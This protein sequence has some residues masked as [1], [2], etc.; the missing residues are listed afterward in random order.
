[1]NEEIWRAIVACDSSFDGRVYYGLKTTGIYC[2]PS[3]KSRTPKQENVRIYHSIAEAHKA[4]LRP[5]KRCRPDEHSNATH[6]EKLAH[7]LANLIDEHYQEPLT[8]PVM[9]SRL[10][11]SPFHMH[12]SF[13]RVMGITPSKYLLQKRIEHAMKMLQDRNETITNI[14]SAVGFQNSN[15]FSSMFHKVTGQSPSEYRRNVADQKKEW[16]PSCH[17]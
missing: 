4:G 13:T 8:L 11:I 6:E 15:Q 12:R 10:F 17:S 3:C 16:S 2:K 9:A 14:A 1:M 7:Q 5:C